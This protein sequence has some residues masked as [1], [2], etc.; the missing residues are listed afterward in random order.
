MVLWSNVPCIRSEVWGFESCFHQLFISGRPW[1]AR[2]EKNGN[3]EGTPVNTI[4][5]RARSNLDS[6]LKT[7]AGKR[8]DSKDVDVDWTTID[9]WNIH[10]SKISSWSKKIQFEEFSIEC[11]QSSW[12]RR[13]G[14]KN[15]WYIS[16][17]I[18]KWSWLIIYNNNWDCK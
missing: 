8:L 9:A 18:H 15:Y 12:M 5:A 2:E 11:Y 1:R 7:W 3:D 16:V 17:F 14:E 10:H 6:I 4:D 13:D